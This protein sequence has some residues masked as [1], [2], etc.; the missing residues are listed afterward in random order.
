MESGAA[1]SGS[2][3]RKSVMI[4]SLLVVVTIM[5]IIG[6]LLTHKKSTIPAVSMTRSGCVSEQFIVG[7][8]G[9]CVSDIQNLVNFIETDGLTECTFVGGQRL[10][11]NGTYDTTTQAQITVVQKW[12]NCDY[13]HYKRKYQHSNVVRAL[14]V[15]LRI[16]FKIR[17]RY[18]S[19]PTS[20]ACGRKSRR[21]CSAFH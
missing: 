19:I 18:F 21:L 15:W 13:H 20:W 17:F 11:I 8:S 3:K 9:T 4:I 1:T 10:S 12:E 6:F 7:S 14:Y 5:V 2:S 16:S